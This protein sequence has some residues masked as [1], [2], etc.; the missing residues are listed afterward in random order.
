MD[1]YDGYFVEAPILREYY[2][3]SIIETKYKPIDYTLLS[4][5]IAD[6]IKCCYVH[7][8]TFKMVFEDLEIDKVFEFTEDEEFFDS[9]T[10]DSLAFSPQDIVLVIF[11]KQTG[12]DDTRGGGCGDK[13]IPIEEFRYTINNREGITIRDLTEAVY[14]MKGSKYDNYYE[15]FLKIKI[16]EKD[17][18]RV[19]V[20]AKFDY[21]S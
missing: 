3:N 13:K 21:G 7:P 4:L 15:M 16:R 10:W 19:L 6:S 1:S 2:P 8:V 12:N 18:N 14:R 5:V 11:N 20:E 17:Q 9:L